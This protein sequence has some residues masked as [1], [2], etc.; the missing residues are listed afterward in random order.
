MESN[1]LFADWLEGPEG[2]RISNQLEGCGVG[3]RLWALAE[4]YRRSRYDTREES[5]AISGFDLQPVRPH[6]T[7]SVA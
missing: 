2:R 5:I 3:E 1:P 6:A 4:A 7:P